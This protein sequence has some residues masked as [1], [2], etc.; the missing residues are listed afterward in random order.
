MTWTYNQ[1]VLINALVQLHKLTG[2]P[3]ALATARRI[4][5]A[6]TT[7]TYLSPNGILRE[8]N[9]PDACGGD[10]VSFKGAAIR[11]LGVLNSATGRAYN[12]YLRRNADSAYAAGPQQHRL[13]RLAL[14]RPV[15]RNQPQLP[16][17]RGGPAQRGAVS[18]RPSSDH[19]HFPRYRT[20]VKWPTLA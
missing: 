1:G 10:G 8:P 12:T 17:Q 19:S 16:A 6:M 7:S 2:D 13:V 4:A 3:N 14:G 9:K 18:R 20:L 11:G 15:H 5:D